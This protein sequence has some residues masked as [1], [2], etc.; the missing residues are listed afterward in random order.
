MTAKNLLS[1]DSTQGSKAC[2]DASLAPDTKRMAPGLRRLAATASVSL[3]LCRFNLRRISFTAAD[4]ISPSNW[5]VGQ[6]PDVIFCDEDPRLKG[7]ESF[8]KVLPRWRPAG[9]KFQSAISHSKLASSLLLRQVP[10]SHRHQST[11]TRR[12][13]QETLVR[14]KRSAASFSGV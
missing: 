8:F 2:C 14:L 1:P 3:I 10:R 6:H 12:I 9:H 4:W 11:P 13:S 7:F 5:L